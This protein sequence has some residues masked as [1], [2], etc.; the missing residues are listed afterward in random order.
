[1]ARK[2]AALGPTPVYFISIKP[3]KLRFAEFAEQTQ[4]NDA[5][6]ALAVRRTDLRYIDIV[7][8][9][10]DAGRPKDLFLQDQ[11][12]MGPEGYAIWAQAVRKALLSTTD[13]EEHA[14]RLARPKTG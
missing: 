5:I 1:M 11:L 9:M 14:C 7:A 6:R 2:T 8:P 4:A 3:S 10:L 13:Y 12:H